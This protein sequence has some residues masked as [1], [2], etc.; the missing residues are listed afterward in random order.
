MIADKILTERDFVLDDFNPQSI[1]QKLAGRMKCKRLTLNLS[2]LALSR[3]SGVSLGSLKRF[4]H[5]H[6]IS[7]AHLLQLALALDALDGF[8]SL[9][10]ENEYNSI[11][12]IISKKK[13]KQRKR[14]RNA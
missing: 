4:E 1:A 7:L 5:Q 12:E 11:D 8:H 6:K 10:P 9:F 14:G 2:Q 3:I 13:V